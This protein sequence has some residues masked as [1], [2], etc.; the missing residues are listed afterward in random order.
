MHLTE[1]DIRHLADLA[2][3]HVSDE[4]AARLSRDLTEIVGF[5]D[6]AANEDISGVE[7]MT[8]PTGSDG[9]VRQDEAFSRE[10]GRSFRQAAETEDGYVRV[11][12]VRSPLGPAEA[13][14]RVES[15]DEDTDSRGGSIE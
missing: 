7:P 13:E 12:P 14:E 3:L 10:V 2:R 4:E 1:S 11:P 8:R 9:E 15:G 6:A 5:I